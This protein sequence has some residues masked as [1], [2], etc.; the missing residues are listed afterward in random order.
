MTPE[1]AGLAV[2]LQQ[3]AEAAEQARTARRKATS[4]LLLAMIAASLWILYSIITR[5]KK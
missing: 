1:N 5:R 2:T 3:H 4:L